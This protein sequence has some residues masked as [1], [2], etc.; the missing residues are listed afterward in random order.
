ME[1]LRLAQDIL[2]LQAL[3]ET[4]V[5]PSE[6]SIDHYAASHASGPARVL[7]LVHE[8]RL[9]EILTYWASSSDDPKKVIALCIEENRNGQAMI[10]R[11]AVNHGNLDQVKV[12]LEAM[13]VTLEK[14]AASSN[15]VLGQCLQTLRRQM[16]DLNRNRILARLRSRHAKLKAN[17]KKK[18]EARRKLSPWM[19]ELAEQ[20]MLT[21]SPSPLTASTRQDLYIRVK[22]FHEMFLALET[23]S[24]T[25]V[26]AKE[27]VDA[28]LIITQ[29]AH[30]MTAD[31]PLKEVLSSVPSIANHTASVICKYI[32]KL[33]YYYTIPQELF[34]AASKYTIFKAI[35]VAVA[36]YAPDTKATKTTEHS[37]SS[38]V[39]ARLQSVVDT[40][41][42]LLNNGS[43]VTPDLLAQ[44][45]QYQNL[46]S[47]LRC[48][49]CSKYPVHAEIQLLAYYELHPSRLPPRVILSS[50]K[51]CYLCN[52]FFRYHGKYFIANSHGRAYEKWALPQAL[53]ELGP[54]EAAHITSVIRKFEAEVRRKADA[55][56]Q[57]GRRPYQN[58]N[59]SNVLKSVVWSII[60]RMSKRGG[61]DMT[62]RK[63]MTNASKNHSK[64]EESRMPLNQAYA[65][66]RSP[67]KRTAS[68]SPNRR[69]VKIS[70]PASSS[71]T[72]CSVAPIASSSQSLCVPH[73]HY[74]SNGHRALTRL[75]PGEPVHTSLSSLEPTF[76]A[77][78]PNIRLLLSSD[79]PETSELQYRIGIKLLPMH[80]Q[81]VD[82]LPLIVDIG[83][84]REGEDVVIEGNSMIMLRHEDAI[85][86]EYALQSQTASL[87][88][89]K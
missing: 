85:S 59:E 86:I 24:G 7:S 60:S 52:L 71:S 10:I 1:Q 6:N 25:Q 84:M 34:H 42:A 11:L 5:P 44:M 20:M 62:E 17:F 73:H 47:Q 81:R 32:S 23:M 48:L 63:V 65:T 79:S 82:L 41:T 77:R 87:R 46:Q 31:F 88:T 80:E 13:K 69:S 51:A 36:K 72:V 75:R 27:G 8:R 2:I 16:A 64:Q 89:E 15:V 21:S 14:G 43:V 76:Y 53:H 4:P 28:L 29:Y 70:E 45:N 68:S 40:K 19:M 38:G 56:L 35:T 66:S 55:A 67:S 33:G 22:A 26:K 3:D 78:T 49:D 83:T 9:V 18:K 74:R 54:A 61:H 12:G 39:V 57:S 37:Q 58:P 30:Q 50:K